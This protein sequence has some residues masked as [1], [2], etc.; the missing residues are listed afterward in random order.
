MA[1][2]DQSNMEQPCG[3][4]LQTMATPRIFRGDIALLAVHLNE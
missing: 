3:L 2:A 4:M 1:E